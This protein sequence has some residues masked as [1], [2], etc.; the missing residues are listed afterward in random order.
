MAKAGEKAAAI[1]LEE[2]IGRLDAALAL[3]ETAVA[4]RLEAERSRGDRETEFALLEEDRA[5]LA[6]ELDAAGARL[7][8]MNVTTGEVGRRLDRAIETVKDVLSGPSGS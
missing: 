1:P 3:L 8:R 6:A 4:R 5:R 2:A 7:A